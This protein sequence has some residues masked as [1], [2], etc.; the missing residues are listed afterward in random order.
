MRLPVMSRISQPK[1]SL[2]SPKHLH[3]HNEVPHIL[4]LMYTGWKE[5]VALKL[6]KRL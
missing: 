4:H 3:H 6:Y 2:D 5:D 1:A